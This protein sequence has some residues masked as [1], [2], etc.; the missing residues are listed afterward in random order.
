MPSTRVT[1]MATVLSNMPMCS[2]WARSD[3]P[4]ASSR[5]TTSPGISTQARPD[6][7]IRHSARPC[8][9]EST[10]TSTPDVWAMNPDLRIR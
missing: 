4:V 8:A 6:P 1:W 9:A 5:R 2:G 3:R 7:L 10:W